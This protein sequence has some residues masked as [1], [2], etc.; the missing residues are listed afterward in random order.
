[1]N[2]TAIAVGINLRGWGMLAQKRDM[3]VLSKTLPLILCGLIWGCSPPANPPQTPQ[4]DSGATF[5]QYMPKPQILIFSG[6]AAWR[7]EDGIAGGD[8]FWISHAEAEGLGYLTTERPA[9]F[10]ADVL[11]DVSVVVLNSSTGPVLN[12]EQRQVLRE[13]VKGGGGIVATHGSGD[14]SH[15]WDWY[16]DTLI[17]PRFV[18][19][20]M[21]PQMQAADVV[22]LTAGHPVLN[23][24][25]ARFSHVDEWYTFEGALNGDFTPIAGLDES[26][27]SPVN[28]VYGDR[29]DL[30]MGP[31]P[32]DHP[33]IWSRCVGE[34][35]IVYSA[36]GHTSETYE[37]P[38]HQTILKNALDWASAKTDPDGAFC[39]N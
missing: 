16:Q 6:T 12:A 38:H 4:A 10:N 17:G 21:A 37:N 35:R 5:N 24:V 9:T 19:H 27:Y 33:I 13:F 30:R 25:P 7:H 2:E 11:K 15:E 36:L 8:Q 29:S 32:I 20:P 18:S 26:T 39:E 28:T 14:A 23:G 22:T 34:G 3:T 1:M 31:N